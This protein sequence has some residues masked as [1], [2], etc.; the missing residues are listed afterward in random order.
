MT[1]GDLDAAER[2]RVPR[3]HFDEPD[4][5]CYAGYGCTDDC[6][7]GGRGR[8]VPVRPF[9]HWSPKTCDEC[10]YALDCLGP[11]T[12]GNLSYAHKLSRSSR[13]CNER[14]WHAKDRTAEYTQPPPRSPAPL[15]CQPLPVARLVVPWRQRV[16]RHY[17]RILCIALLAAIFLMEVW[18]VGA[19]VNLAYRT[20]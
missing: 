20:L 12:N 19:L 18:V 7:V 9:L 3:D 15:E 13:C 11:D 16:E 14:A 4:K 8:Q 5:S 6:P 10:G 2:S 1:V 17:I